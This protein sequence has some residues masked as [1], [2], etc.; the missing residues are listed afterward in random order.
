MSCTVSVGRPSMKY[1]FTR[2]QPASKASLAPLRITSSVRP[3]LITSLKRCEPASG[4]KVRL[5]FLI[6]CTL[7]MTSRE[8]ASILRDGREILT[9]FPLNSSIRKFT[10]PSSWL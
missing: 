9:P 8:N 5:L 4:A 6:S 2:F 7:L 3:L 1:S 10:S